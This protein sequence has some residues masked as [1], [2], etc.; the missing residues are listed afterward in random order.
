[1]RIGPLRCCPR[2]LATNS[3]GSS[4]VHS[5]RRQ[6]CHYIIQLHNSQSMEL[7][8]RTGPFWFEFDSLQV[9]RI[10]TRLWGRFRTRRCTQLKRPSSNVQ[11]LSS[12][13][14]GKPIQRNQNQSAFKFIKSLIHL[15]VPNVNLLLFLNLKS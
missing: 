2:C 13:S 12:V 5:R 6:S 3:R 7:S 14:V 1:M 15:Y 10:K 8:L 4:P 11:G 9:L